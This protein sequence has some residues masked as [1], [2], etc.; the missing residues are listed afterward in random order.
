MILRS[1]PIAGAIAL[2]LLTPS[3]AF[4]QAETTIARD[5]AKMAELGTFATTAKAVGLTATLAKAGPFTLFAPND[6]AFDKLPA[7]TVSTL[8]KAENRAT[9]ATLLSYHVVRG[10]LSAK[11]LREAIAR[12]DGRA[13]LDTLQ[14]EPLI[15]SRVAGEIVLIDAKGSTSRI[16]QP[17]RPE[18]N[19]V[20]YIVDTVL[21]P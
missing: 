12:G 6:A 2:L 7:G 8:L 13:V 21:M 14:G 1:S 11:D 20:L 18:K 9:L 3:P 10:R 15:A 5:A 4:A 19:G 17:E 16:V